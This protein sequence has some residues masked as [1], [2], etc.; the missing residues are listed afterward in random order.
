[1]IK[2]L[3]PMKCRDKKRRKRSEAPVLH[4]PGAGVVVGYR[5]KGPSWSSN[6]DLMSKEKWFSFEARSSKDIQKR[7]EDQ[8]KFMKSYLRF[9]WG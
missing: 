3:K 5:E 8:R 6:V 9:L 4:G 2:Y 1:M 7:G